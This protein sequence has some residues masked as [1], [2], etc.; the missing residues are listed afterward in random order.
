MSEEYVEFTI[1]N[2]P[3]VYKLAY[4]FNHMCDTELATGT[5]LMEPFLGRSA[6]NANQVRGLLTAC[7]KKA[8]P[9][10]LLIEAGELLSRDLDTVLQALAKTIRKARAGHLAEDQV[11]A[12][13][14]AE[15]SAAA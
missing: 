14:A 1:E 6:M 15:E 7:L 4:D 12:E 3:Q 10:V 5:N 8:H 13:E 11:S 9:A 2:D